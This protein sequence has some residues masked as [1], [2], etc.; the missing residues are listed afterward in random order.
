[1][2]KLRKR[3]V[4]ELEK[5]PGVT[6]EIWPDRK[7]GFS[8][9][10]YNQKEFAHFHNDNELDIR[11]SKKI[12]SEQKLSRLT[13]SAKHPKR[14]GN[15]PWIEFRFIEGNDT[16]NILRLVKLLQKNSSGVM[17]QN[18]YN[19]HVVERGRVAPLK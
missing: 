16:E 4:Q 18:T 3:L 15:S 6:E 1:M 2:S 14:S 9:L 10:H 7:D 5:I 13:N 19:T 17:S 11:L 8:T 12:I